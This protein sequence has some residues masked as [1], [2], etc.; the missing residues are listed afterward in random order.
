MNKLLA[1]SA[2]SSAALR[3]GKVIDKSV[4]ARTK[5]VAQI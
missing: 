4:M 3:T 2:D 1:R 5:N